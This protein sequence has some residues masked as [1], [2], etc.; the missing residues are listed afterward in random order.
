MLVNILKTFYKNISYRLYIVIELT[1]F[2]WNS[3]T[4]M[5]TSEGI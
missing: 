1:G 2:V 5:Q 3:Q 4:D